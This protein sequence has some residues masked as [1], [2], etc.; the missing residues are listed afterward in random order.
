MRAT[1]AE[2]IAIPA[3]APAL[4]LPEL[5]VEAIL[6]LD[7]ES[8]SCDA[9]G[10]VEEPCSEFVEVDAEIEID[11]GNV[12]VGAVVVL[13]IVETLAEYPPGWRLA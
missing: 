10:D 13:I 6:L 7:D 5:S 9:E 2:L 8:E 4:S 12:W 1:T 11:V 3:I